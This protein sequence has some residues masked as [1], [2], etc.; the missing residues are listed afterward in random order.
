MDSAAV[1]LA[2]DDWLAGH[3]GLRVIAV[4]AALPGE[5]DLAGFVARHPARCW[6]YP[7]VAGR[8]LTFHA[9]DDPSE[10]WVV[11]AFGILEPA[12][13]LAEIPL[14]RIDAFLCPGLAFDACG[15]RLGRGL[16]Y[17]D[18]MLA[19]APRSSLKVGVCFSYQRV[20]DT[21]SEPHDIAMDSVI[22]D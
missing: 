7:R 15:G 17:Y 5:V 1:C 22:S 18:R 16:G 12:G 20:A 2:M 19:M 8:S 10:Q 13:Q 6:V 11:G 9:V 4:F 21:F 3:A 14:D